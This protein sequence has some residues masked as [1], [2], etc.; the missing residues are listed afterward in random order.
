MHW[1]CFWFVWFGV[2]VFAGFWE[3]HHCNVRTGRLNQWS[4]SLA[5]SC[6]W[7]TVLS[8]CLILPVL[9]LLFYSALYFGTLM[10]AIHWSVK[11]LTPASHYLHSCYVSIVIEVKFSVI[12][13]SPY[14]LCLPH[15]VT[16]TLTSSWN[17]WKPGLNVIDISM[18]CWYRLLDIHI[19]TCTT[20]FSID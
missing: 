16:L 6:T 3:R 18:W 19:C 20:I 14:T 12:A 2:L 13:F 10:S 17:D 15:V 4:S 5:G 9:L 11:L 1:C 8:P 7:V